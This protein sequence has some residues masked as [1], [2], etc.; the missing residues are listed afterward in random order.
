MKTLVRSLY[1]AA[2][3]AAVTLG[4]FND[5]P[6]FL[7]WLYM[8]FGWLGDLAAAEPLGTIALILA[9][10][11]IVLLVFLLARGAPPAL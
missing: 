1:L 6:P 4:L 5:L 8:K 9:V 10:V 2:E 7:A 3:K 11:A